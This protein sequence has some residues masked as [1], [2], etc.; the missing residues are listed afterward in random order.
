MSPLGIYLGVYLVSSKSLKCSLSNSKRS[1]YQFNT[2][3]GKVGRLAAVPVTIELLKSKCLSSLYYGLEACP[4]STADFGI[5]SCR[6]IREN[7]QY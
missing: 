2:I 6:R 3:F 7:I 4:F 5:C 1:F